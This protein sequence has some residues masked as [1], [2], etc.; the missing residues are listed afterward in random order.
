MAS[1]SSGRIVVEFESGPIER[2]VVDIAESM[3]EAMAHLNADPTRIHMLKRLM[4]VALVDM[5]RQVPGGLTL[6]ELLMVADMLAVK[7]LCDFVALDD[8]AIDLM[9]SAQGWTLAQAMRCKLFPSGG[10]AGMALDAQ[11]K[12]GGNDGK[13]S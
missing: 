4:R 10:M 8:G 13:P 6:A 7:A 12:T 9:R 5:I 3:V 11:T 1:P 2:S